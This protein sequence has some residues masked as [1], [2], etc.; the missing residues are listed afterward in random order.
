[1]CC[2]VGQSHLRVSSGKKFLMHKADWDRFPSPLSHGKKELSSKLHS[3]L[4]L[5]S[6][7]HLTWQSNNPNLAHIFL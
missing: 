7:L 4:L 6:A 1:M 3:T 5:A 2:T